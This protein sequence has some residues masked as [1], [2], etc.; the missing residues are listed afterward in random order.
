M[1]T[2]SRRQCSIEKI[3]SYR[4]NKFILHD[5]IDLRCFSADLK[6]AVSNPGQLPARSWITSGQALGFGAEKSAENRFWVVCMFDFPFCYFLVLFPLSLFFY[7]TTSKNFVHPQNIL[8]KFNFSLKKLER[9][10]CLGFK[11]QP[12][13]SLQILMNFKL[14]RLGPHYWPH[15]LNSTWHNYSIQLCPSREPPRDRWRDHLLHK[16]A[17][18]AVVKRH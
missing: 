10:K 2:S 9:G 12:R 13:L 18:T 5:I 16:L 14:V 7:R 11:Y 17:Y 4:M 6:R 15:K 8:K 1:F 3:W